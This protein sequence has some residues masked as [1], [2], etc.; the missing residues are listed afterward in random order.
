M[1]RIVNQVVLYMILV[2][3]CYNI[4]IVEIFRNFEIFEL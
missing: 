3:F 1:S 4:V 2:F